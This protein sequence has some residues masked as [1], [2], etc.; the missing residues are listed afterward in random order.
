VTILFPYSSYDTTSFKTFF[1]FLIPLNL[2][3]NQAFYSS[4]DAFA[5]SSNLFIEESFITAVV[6]V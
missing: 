6:L 3:F 5:S 2:L 1:F 4:C